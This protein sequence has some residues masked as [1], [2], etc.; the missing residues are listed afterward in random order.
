MDRQMIDIKGYWK[1]NPNVVIENDQEEKASGYDERYRFDGKAFID[2]DGNIM[3]IVRNFL[4]ENEPYLVIGTKMVNDDGEEEV[5][6]N[7]LSNQGLPPTIYTAKKNEFNVYTGEY[8]IYDDYLFP[9]T[10]SCQLSIQENKIGLDLDAKLSS[11]INSFVD[12]SSL[13]T[14]DTIDKLKNDS[15]YLM[16]MPVYEE[17]KVY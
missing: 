13:E 16:G 6:L 7:K 15:T 17:G 2:N 10:G 9:N 5:I 8:G 14:K 12:A 4:F 11:E 3:G 1:V